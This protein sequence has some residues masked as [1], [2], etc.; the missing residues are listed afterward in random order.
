MPISSPLWS[1]STPLRSTLQLPDQPLI[2][3]CGKRVGLPCVQATAGSPQPTN[4][5]VLRERRLHVFD[6][7]TGLKFLVDS[8]SVVSLLPYTI[9]RRKLTCEAPK[10]TAANGTSIKTYGQHVM[11]LN[12]GLRRAFTWAFILAD[13]KSAIIGADLLANFGL[14]IDLKHRRLLDSITSCATRGF[15]HPASV[16][17][18]SATMPSFSTT[19]H[20]QDKLTGLLKQFQRLAHADNSPR[21]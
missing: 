11:T 7:N 1:R 16:S 10:F 3:L 14:I 20:L 21:G 9:S 12:L 5:P 4:Q 18:I 2:Q 15:L 6:R 8:G 13:V 19:S 17:G